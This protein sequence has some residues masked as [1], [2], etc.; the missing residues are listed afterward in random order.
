MASNSGGDSKFDL[1]FLGKIID[2]VND[3]TLNHVISWLPQKDVGGVVVWEG[4]AFERDILPRYFRSASLASFTRQMNMYGFHKVANS[5][6]ADLE[7]VHPLFLEN[8]PQL[9]KKISRKVARKDSE[10]DGHKK[11]QTAKSKAKDSSLVSRQKSGASSS[12]GSSVP[13][14]SATTQTYQLAN[15]E[16]SRVESSNAVL[17]EEI[18]ELKKLADYMRNT[19]TKLR[20]LLPTDIEPQE[21]SLLD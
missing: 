10:N 18:E 20:A 1:P 6:N 12:G 19:L 7:F 9:W 13:K 17:V 3:P 14:P 2:M 16:L 11:M 4:Y 21:S 5:N 15:E 8:R